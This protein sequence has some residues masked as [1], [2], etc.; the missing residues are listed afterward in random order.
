M[1]RFSRLVDLRKIREE[2]DGL[3]YARILARIETCRQ[4]IRELE[5]ETAQGH[6]MA[7]EEVAQGNAAGSSMYD[8]F[9]RGQKFRIKKLEDKISL[10]QV[11]AAAAQ[12]VWLASRTQ[13]R[14]SESMAKKE[15]AHRQMEMRHDDNKELDMIGIV[16]SR[17][18]PLQ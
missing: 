3:A 15:E 5:K 7:C 10:A 11:E 12:K 6:E 16:Q 2:A 4:K 18:R 13:L 9:F 8:D 14:Q 17:F 1:G